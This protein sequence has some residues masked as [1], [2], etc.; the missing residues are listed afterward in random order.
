LPCPDGCACGRHVKPK[1]AGSPNWVGD[2]ISHKSM[3]ARVIQIRGAAR[4][5][6]CLFCAER[7]LTVPALDWAQLNHA[8]GLDI[9]D[10]IPLCRKC[11]LRYDLDIG[12]RSR[13]SRLAAWDMRRRKAT[14]LKGAA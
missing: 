10:Y 2:A 1:G 6:R 9:A 12:A 4:T 8:K 5:H 3:H 13:E 11:H 7:E 14:S